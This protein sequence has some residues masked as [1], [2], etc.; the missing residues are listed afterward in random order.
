M[1]KQH[2]Q[3]NTRAGVQTKR[4]LSNRKSRN[5]LSGPRDSKVNKNEIPPGI[6][7][8]ICRSGVPRQRRER[9]E[10]VLPPSFPIYNRQ[11]TRRRRH[12]DSPGVGHRAAAR[13]DSGVPG[14]PAGVPTRR[15]TVRQAR[16]S[17]R[18]PRWNHSLHFCTE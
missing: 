15:V 2:K 5:L 10:I 9:I 12:P 16:T 3:T 6:I 7:P 1:N 17:Q 13:V 8:K 4:F 14:V 11:N 18:P